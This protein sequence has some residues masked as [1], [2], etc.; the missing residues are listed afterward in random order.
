MH[1]IIDEVK[2]YI[3]R[4]KPSFENST[5]LF[6][7]D[8]LVHIYII[9]LFSFNLNLKYVLNSLYK[10]MK[11]YPYNISILDRWLIVGIIFLSC[12]FGAG[13]FIRQY[14]QAI[15]LKIYKKLI[16]K[17]FVIVKTSKEVDIGSPNGGFIIGMLERVFILLVMAIGQPS[18]AGFVLTAKSIARFKKMDDSGFAEYFIIGTFISF[19]FAIFGGI[20]IKTLQVI[21]VIK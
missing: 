3:V 7:I 14:I 5:G 9:I 16:D 13:V 20:I 8:Q 19:I 4:I 17:K 1:F 10:V 12:T 15:N 2:S 18:M 6:I 21:P 11:S